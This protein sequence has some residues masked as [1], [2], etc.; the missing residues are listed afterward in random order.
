MAGDSY[1]AFLS[2]SRADEVIGDRI[3]KKLKKFRIPRKF[4]VGA[5]N[6]RFSIFRDVH[7]AELGEYDEV[8]ENALQASNFLIVLCSPSARASKYVINEIKRFIEFH[9]KSSVIPVLVDGRP[10]KEVGSD[11]PVQDQAFPDILYK[12]FDEPIAADFRPKAKESFLLKRKRQREAFFQ[13]VAKL[14]QQPKSDELVRRNRQ[15]RLL[16]SVLS[17]ILILSSSG[18]GSWFLYDRLPNPGLDPLWL[19][20]KS[21][22]NERIKSGLTRISKALEQEVPKRG[23]SNQLII[24]TWNIREF[25]TNKRSQSPPR[26][27]EPLAYIALIFSYFDIVAVQELTGSA[28]E[29]ESAKQKLLDRLGSHWQYAG[30]GVT[31]GSLGNNE[32]LGFFF[33]TRSVQRNGELDE[34]VLPEQIMK[35]VGLDRQIARTPLIAGF[36]KGNRKITLTNARIYYGSLSGEKRQERLIEFTA[37]VKYL[38]TIIKRGHVFSEHLILMGDLNFDRPDAPEAYV[39]KEAE[40][41]FPKNLLEAPSNQNMTRP[42]DQIILSWN[43]DLE[44]P[45]VTSAG[46]FKVFDHVYRNKDVDTYMAIIKTE[47]ASSIRKSLVSKDPRKYFKQWRTN[48][49]SDHFPKWVVLNLDCR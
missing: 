12:Y 8:I 3:E 13:I 17:V 24:A 42:Y 15:K 11:D 21:D 31:E 33:D 35:N 36:N 20:F 43:A 9:G 23:S 46:V 16:I 5:I 18:F 45:C 1:S 25:A 39:A 32:R 28:N 26:S 34:I 41:T 40:F 19:L 7:D 30:S 27:T 2:Y 38:R 10:N 22:H 44:G 49:M 4:R 14:L 47:L 37:L 29:F 6:G 48:K